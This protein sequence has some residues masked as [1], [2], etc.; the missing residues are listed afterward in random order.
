MGEKC[1]RERGGRDDRF[2]AW[3]SIY[4]CKSTCFTGKKLLGYTST[5]VLA[6]RVQILTLRERDRLGV[7]YSIYLLYWYKV[8]ALLAQSTD[9][10]AERE[11]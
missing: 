7:W 8:L 1:V 9:T 5:K 4:W 10:D 6:L 2:G 3:D 11:R